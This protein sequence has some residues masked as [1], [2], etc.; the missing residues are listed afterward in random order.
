LAWKITLKDTLLTTRAAL[1]V[2]V[3]ASVTMRIAAAATRGDYLGFDESMYI[4]LGRN[5]L[6]G[7]GYVL[8]GLPNA[9]FPYGISLLA[10]VGDALFGARWALSLPSA[11]LGGLAVIPLY[12]LAARMASRVTA[13]AA[14]VL[15]AGFPSLLFF[16]PFVSYGRRLYEGSEQI[17]IFLTLAMAYFAYSAIVEGRLRQFVFAGL[18]C[19]AAF[20]VRQEAAALCALLAAWMLLAAAWRRSLRQL[21]KALAFPAAAL[22]VALPFVIHVRTVTGTFGPGMRLAGS[23]PMRDAFMPVV[24]KNDCS[25]ALNYLLAL[26]KDGVELEHAYYGVSDWHRDRLRSGTGGVG[27]MFSDLRPG[28]VL[29][30]VRL[31][32]EKVVPDKLIPLLLAGFVALFVGQ[33]RWVNAAFIAL[34]ALPAMFLAMALFPLA[35]FSFYL[36]PYAVLLIASGVC[37]VLEVA[38]MAVKRIAPYGPAAVVAVAALLSAYGAWD[39]LSAQKGFRDIR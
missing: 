13:L 1:I 3:A 8:N 36:A 7:K 18:F 35:R 32:V 26:N 27:A 25:S 34:L 17:Y 19:G 12:H 28:Y 33:R 9:T 21:A 4:L 22:L 2:I 37:L 30:A 24:E 14:A 38:G 23:L 16:S 11:V 20:E 5:L 10:G 15:Y 6:S 29:E 39:S 31:F